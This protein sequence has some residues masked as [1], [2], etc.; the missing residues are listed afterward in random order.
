[1]QILEES[2]TA[3][4]DREHKFLDME[5][6]RRRVAKIKNSWSPE[7]ARARAAEGARRRQE[8]ENFVLEGICDVSTSEETCD[9][10]DYGFSLVG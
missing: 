5:T 8:L 4:A 6:I 2:R 10:S 1:M 3:V 9:I 7:T